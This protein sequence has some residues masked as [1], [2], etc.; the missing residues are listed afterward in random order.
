MAKVKKNPLGHLS[1][2]PDL[3]SQSQKGDHTASRQLLQL[4]AVLLI[5]GS[6]LRADLA[7]WIGAG[8]EKVAKGETANS[9]FDLAKRKGNPGYGEEFERLIAETV[10]HSTSGR[11]KAINADGTS[12]GV[13]A[14]LLERYGLS[15]TTSGDFY[16]NHIDNILLDEKIRQE[17]SNEKPNL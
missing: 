8:L 17:F 7:G 4:A 13:Y 10:H 1:T 11:H 9:S 6:P 15:A 2:V 14:E 12:Q 5:E 3:I 16:D